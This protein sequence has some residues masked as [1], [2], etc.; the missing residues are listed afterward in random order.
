MGNAEGVVVGPIGGRSDGNRLGGAELG[1]AGLGGVMVVAGWSLHAPN[2]AS[3]LR[4]DGCNQAMLR[5]V[6][7][8]FLDV[9]FDSNPRLPVVLDLSPA[10]TCR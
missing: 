10:H 2:D 1:G 9:S 3:K 5:L 4:Y 8:R 7:L 6:L